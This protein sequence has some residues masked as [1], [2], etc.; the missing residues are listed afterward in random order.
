MQPMPNVAMDL[1]PFRLIEDF[2]APPGV[3]AIAERPMIAVD[4]GLESFT[5]ASKV[6]QSQAGSACGCS[7]ES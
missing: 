7:S 4:A 3:K 2:V 6:D 1:V 5:F